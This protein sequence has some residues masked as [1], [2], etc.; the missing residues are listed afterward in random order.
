MQNITK[1]KS[2]VFLITLVFIFLSLSPI[3]ISHKINAEPINQW[4]KM[5]NGGNNDEAQSTATDSYNNIIVTGFSRINNIYKC[6]TIKY[7]KDGTEIFSKTYQSPHETKAYDVAIDSQD[8]IILVGYSYDTSTNRDYLLIKYDKD[9]TELFN[10]TYD[11]GGQDIAYSVDVDSQDNII[12][13]GTASEDYYTIKYSSDGIKIWDVAYSTSYESCAKGIAV[14]NND[15]II[16]TGYKHTQNSRDWHTIKYD[17]NGNELF[18]KTYY[19]GNYNKAVAVSTDSQNNIVIVGTLFSVSGNTRIHIIKYNQ[20][21]VKQWSK[22]YD[23]S[24]MDYAADITTNS[25]DDIIVIGS[26]LFANQGRNYIIVKYDSAG[27]QIWSTFYDRHNENDFAR[28][29]TV[30]STNKIIVTGL[31]KNKFTSYYDYTTI[32]YVGKPVANF[33]YNPIEPN[34]F[35][36]IQFND[37]STDT[38]GEI[39]EWLWDF[40]DGNIST[41]QNPTYQYSNNGVYNVKLTVTDDDYSSNTTTKQIQVYNT[42]PTADFNWIQISGQINIL[43]TDQSSDQDGTV[44]S[45]HWDFGDG[46]TGSGEIIQH[47]Y[48]NIGIYNTTLTVTDNDGATDEITKQIIVTDNNPPEI[49]DNTA[50]VAYTGD[51]FVFNAT[52]TDDIEVDFVQ[53][54]YWYQGETSSTHNMINVADNYYKYAKTINHTLKPLHYQII[55]KDTSNNYNDTNIKDIT[56]YDND[57]PAITDQTG[58][59]AYTGKQFNFNAT[60]TDNIE[61]ENVY[62]EYWYGTEAPTNISMNLLT[63]NF[64]KK[65][66]TIE[67]R[68]DKLHYKIS[69]KDTSKNWNNTSIKTITIIDNDKP[70]I[71]NINAN[72]NPQEHAGHV[73]ITC[74]VH[75]NIEIQTVKINIQGPTGFTPINTTMNGNYYYNNT[76]NI[77]G[78][79][80]YTIWTQDTS[81]NTKTSQEKT[82]QIKD[83][84]PPKITD[85]TPNTATTGEQ[86]CFSAIIT[87]NVE[88]DRVQVTYW[89]ENHDPN[90]KI[91]TKTLNDFYE[92]TITI[93]DTL[94]PLY[95]EINAKDTSNNW[96]NTGIKNVIIYD[97]KIPEILDNTNNIAYTGDQF[98]FSAIITDNIEI[99]NA[100]VK[101]WYNT[102]P[103]VNT[104]LSN[105]LDDAYEKTITIEDT[106]ETLY[107]IISAKDTSKN[108]NNTSIKTITI[109][110]ND[111]PE[112]TNI[113][114]NPNPQEHA[115]HVNITCNVH[116]NI[117][118]QTVK[119]N[120]QGPTGFTP[121]N[122]TMNGNYYY[123]NTYNILGTYTYT[124]WTQ[125]TSTNTKTSQEKTFQIKDTTPPKITDNTPNTA[126]TGEQFCFSAIITD[127]VEVD[128]AY[129]EYWYGNGNHKT[130]SMTLHSNNYYT[131]TT[132]IDDT[133]KPLHYQIFAYDT[134]ENMKK[135]LTQDVLII[136]ND[137]P[138]IVDQSDD[139]A[140]AGKQFVFKANI[141]DN[142]EVQN[143]K[144]EYWYNK[145]IHTNLSMND[146]QNNIYQK[147][148]TID[149]ITGELYYIIHANDTANNFNNTSIKNVNITDDEPP[150]IR[151][152]SANPEIQEIHEN[153]NITF[154]VNDNIGIDKININITGPE[155]FAPVNKTLNKFYY[156]QVYNILGTYNYYIWVK[157]KSGNTN[158]SDTYN[159]EITD[160]TKPEIIDHTISE[161]EAG[162]ELTFKAEVTD[163]YQVEWAQITYWYKD[164]TA[165]ISYM[166]K[167]SSFYEYTITVTSKPLY[168]SIYAKDTENNA[169]QTS[170]K[171]I[172]VTD[173]TPPEIKN[174]N[175]NPSSQKT[176]KPVQIT[177]QVTDNLQVKHVNISINGPEG[178]SSN[179]PMLKNSET[180]SYTKSYTKTGEYSFFVE[181]T[182]ENNNK[183]TFQ[184]KYFTI[185]NN[186]PEKPY[187][188]DPTDDSINI[189]IETL[190][191]WNCEDPDGDDLTYK[192]Y[193]GE[194]KTPPLAQSNYQNNEYNPEKL[195]PETTYY[196]KIIASDG[197]SQNISLI[198]N[199]TTRSKEQNTIPEKPTKPEGKSKGYIEESYEYQTKTNDS[200][201][202][203]LKYEFNWG[204]ASTI[205]NWMQ[206]NKTI[207]MSHTWD[208]KGTYKV[209]VRAYDGFEWSD[210][211]KELEVTIEEKE[212]N[213]PDNGGN[214]PPVDPPLNNPPNKPEKPTGTT[215]GK[216]GF[217]Y[218][219]ITLTTDPEENNVYYKFNWGDN[220]ESEWKGPYQSNEDITVSHS[221]KNTGIYYIKVKAKDTYDL[222][223]SWSETLK[224]EINSNSDTNK[225]PNKPETPEGTIIGMINEKYQYESST[226]DPDGDDL[227]YLF[228]WDNGSTTNWL[229]N[230]E[231]SH[232]WD[233]T[234]TYK[235]KVKAKDEHNSESTWS[236][237]LT[238]K[239]YAIVESIIIEEKEYLLLGN[240][241]NSYEQIYNPKEKT[242]T[243]LE[244]NDEEY[245]ID[246]NGDGKWDYIYQSSKGSISSYRSEEVTQS[247]T[248]LIAISIIILIATIIVGYFYYKNY[249]QITKTAVC[250]K[251]EEKVKVKGKKGRYLKIKCPNCQTKGNIKI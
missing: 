5:Y 131:Y 90:V 169:N 232:S 219:Y 167:T 31:T 89:Y 243:A 102:E 225:A 120:I 180:Y 127:N 80:T 42:P 202:N 112:I 222:E 166:D 207:K 18:N 100:Y 64:Y 79:Y 208:E 39:V 52:V 144:V 96:N 230:P 103:S 177:C 186:P 1:K 215:E 123:N 44:V 27:N 140:Y 176:D 138:T 248:I 118:I 98:C 109:I 234:G 217:T 135:I 24:I 175:I 113:N 228:N 168:Y 37:T 22:T 54:K 165:H 3:F 170:T 145:N 48:S 28:G 216:T 10:K 143:V 83:T 25:F 34:T 195:S 171:Q 30:D 183:K 213:D 125:D 229:N 218:T 214:N 146:I 115:G 160:T 76:Y 137:K 212:E 43:F 110:D 4:I 53:V 231:A 101:Y 69:A 32:K 74:N 162:E 192:I 33:T 40:G 99:G 60:I 29:I 105:I 87:D 65:S 49:N 58:N 66:I 38:A 46:N 14:D 181:A 2:K 249:D 106:L 233:E 149:D 132:I 211:S 141:E 51:N 191:K 185:Y 26:S 72:P 178:Y 179:Q 85:N 152:I 250:P 205:T 84:T 206:P 159:F 200:N 161:V 56:I 36:L 150:A 15:N 82:F 209:K 78:T 198:W 245:L 19:D 20:D 174:I 77:L 247:N 196:W 8:N 11:S 92:C 184:T 190:L 136:D 61:I 242:F 193:F 189:S 121:I 237:T 23:N 130:Y 9:G 188:P 119:I 21:G 88:V 97:N 62:V 154:I 12:T 81:T 68:L 124:I 155:G 126:T 116:D 95:Y 251:C 241:Q 59:T 6:H 223:S 70:E 114:A 210:W 244:K 57:E 134:S 47:T 199:F 16:V 153:V 75:D 236:E 182:D 151:S 139:I 41:E 55:A 227:K 71:T 45:W 117:E 203:T 240:T 35:D 86:F 220:T 173:N 164:Q 194:E 158:V 108:W 226:T 235:I 224:V 157:D 67:H 163:N 142:I 50:D 246:I 221:W 91:L 187:S 17:S 197:Y 201:G 147:I 122:T 128:T 239:I 129:V 104:T 238:V 107:Y 204:D 111:K 156:N 93:E 73:N 148:I 13:T 63:N 7:D 172:I 133:L 94:K